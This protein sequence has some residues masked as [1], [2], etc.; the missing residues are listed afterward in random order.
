MIVDKAVDSFLE[1]MG[2]GKDES[3]VSTKTVARHCTKDSWSAWSFVTSSCEYNPVLKDVYVTRDEEFTNITFYTH[4]HTLSYLPYD[5]F[6]KLTHG[7]LWTD[8]F[9]NVHRSLIS[10][11]LLSTPLFERGLVFSMSAVG[12][13]PRTGQSKGRNLP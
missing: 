5:E 1:E 9:L 7:P 10:R 12:N 4:T 13:F 8:A 3:S 2:L 6:A 11:Y